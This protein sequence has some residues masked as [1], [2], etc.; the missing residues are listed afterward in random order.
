MIRANCR[1]CDKYFH[2]QGNYEAV[3]KCRGPFR[4]TTAAAISNLREWYQG[5]GSSG[6]GNVDSAA[7][8]AA[9]RF[10]R[11]GGN[12]ASRYLKKVKCAYNP[13]TKACK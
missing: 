6:S 7:D 13:K 5:G 9:N 1:N 3:Y 10:G 4:E 2:C 12:C 11:G 8:Q